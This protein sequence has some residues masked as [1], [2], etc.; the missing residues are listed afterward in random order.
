MAAH[1]WLDSLSEDWP[2]QPP[3]EPSPL[4]KDHSDLPLPENTRPSASK[5]PSPDRIPAIWGGASKMKLPGTVSPLNERTGNHANIP[6]STRHNTGSNNNTQNM[7]KTSMGTIASNANSIIHNTVHIS[8]AQGVNGYTPEWKRRLLQ[9]ELGYGEQRDLFHSA[10][11]EGLENI[12][13]PPLSPPAPS[14]PANGVTSCLDSIR[15]SIEYD[16][17]PPQDYQD[18][19]QHNTTLPSSPPVYHIRR[20]AVSKEFEDSLASDFL[21]HSPSPSPRKLPTFRTNDDSQSFSADRSLQWPLKSLHDNLNANL[22]AHTDDTRKPSNLSVMRNETFSPIIVSPTKNKDGQL[23]LEFAALG[24][25]AMDFRQRLESLRLSR[26]EFSCKTLASN[27]FESFRA[28][29]SINSPEQLLHNEALVNTQRDRTSREIS[30][31]DRFLS[32]GLG[33]ESS[34]MLP[35]ESLQA[36]TPKNFSSVRIDSRPD[37]RTAEAAHQPP[38]AQ[39]VIM[40]D[41]GEDNQAPQ[42]SPLK[43][44]GPYDTYTNQ[45][46]VR[47]ISQFE[48]EMSSSVREPSPETRDVKRKLESEDDEIDGDKSRKLHNFGHG[49]LE[50]FT[51]DESSASPARTPEHESLRHIMGLSHAT[52]EELLIPRARTRGHNRGRSIT[53]D[54]S[55]SNTNHP[56]SHPLQLTPRRDGSLEGK[57]QRT[58]PSKDPTPKRRRTLHKSDVAY[59]VDDF[60]HQVQSTHLLTQS[61]DSHDVGESYMRS[62]RD[63]NDP[64]ERQEHNWLK[65]PP[66]SRSRTPS[67]LYDYP[68]AP[69]SP[70]FSVSPSPAATP[71]RATSMQPNPL[72]DRKPSMK[73]QDF[74][75]EAGKIMAMIRNQV[76]PSSTLDPVSESVTEQ[77]E[78][79]EDEDSY[80][81]ST[82]EP[83]DR[84]PSRENAIPVSRLTM[85][86]MDPEIASKLRKYQELGDM[87]DVISY[88]VRSVSEAHVVIK[89]TQELQQ[90]LEE[91][92]RQTD[93]RKQQAAEIANGGFSGLS[94]ADLP[95]DAE[96]SD[97]PNIQITRNPDISGNAPDQNQRPDDFPSQGSRVSLSNTTSSR[98]SD[99]KK[100]IAPE[101]V[102]HLIPDLVG[103]MF[104]D[105]DK[106]AWVKRK[107]SQPKLSVHPPELPKNGAGGQRQRSG[108][109]AP[110]EVRIPSPSGLAPTTSVLNCDDSSE[111]DPFASIPDLSVDLTKELNNLKLGPGKQADEQAKRFVEVN[112]SPSKTPP[113]SKGTK[114]YVTFSPDTAIG[115]NISPRAFDEFAKLGSRSPSES[116]SP[117]KQQKRILVHG[118]GLPQTTVTQQPATKNRN[119]ILSEQPSC[120]SS[121]APALV[122]APT[123]KPTTPN[124]PLTQ[125]TKKRNAI[126][127]SSPIASVIRDVSTGSEE[128][129]WDL[130]SAPQI[131]SADPDNS[132]ANTP[133]SPT[134]SAL[135]PSLRKGIANPSLKPLSCKPLVT[136][137]AFVPRPVSRIDEREEDDGDGHSPENSV[138]GNYD[139]SRQLT[140]LENSVVEHP[141]SAEKKANTS[142]SF[143][144][145]TP[146]NR[147]IQY[148]NYGNDSATIARNVGRLSLSPLSEFTMHADESYA[149][150]VSY[151]VGDRHLQTGDGYKRVMSIT[152]RD[153]VERLTEAEPSATFWDDL[154]DL[155][156]HE[157]RL[158]SL[159]MLDE[160]CGQLV[161]LDASTNSLTHLDGVPSSLRQLKVTHNSITEMASWDHLMNLQY[162]DLSNNDL[163]SLSALRNLVHLRSVR[164]DNNQLTSLD[165]LG[166]HDGLLS[167][168]AR[169]NNIEELDFADCMF[170]RLGELDVSNN[171]IF[172][173]SNIEAL[174][175]LAVLKLRN[176]NLS[177][178]YVSSKMSSLRDLELGNNEIIS[179]DL[180]YLGSLRVLHA[181]R[182]RITELSHAYHARHLDSLSLR[183][184]HGDAPLNL[185]FLAHAY[186]V[187][188]LF[189]SG[190]SIE[191]FNP[192]VDFLNLQLLELANCGLRE[193]P[194]NL[195]QCMPNLR[196]VNVNFNALE[197]LSPLM[198][199]PRVKRLLAAGNLL[200]DATAIT[201]LLTEFPHI[202]RL[203]LRGN[204]MTL[205]FYPPVMQVLSLSRGETPDPFSLPDVDLERDRAFSTRLDRVTKMRRRLYHMVLVGCCGRLKMLDGLEFKRS[206][207]LGRD[208]L[209]EEI[210]K[211]GMVP[212]ELVKWSLEE[213]GEE[214]ENDNRR[215][216]LKIEGAARP[217][218]LTA[219]EPRKEEKKERR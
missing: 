104:L 217:P 23:E 188:K 203:D 6:E 105:R 58:S 13:K 121:T 50:G 158:S 60:P 11:A 205:G 12:F 24:P 15:P 164:V 168:R 133:G 131:L 46:L 206:E 166:H 107:E 196:T 94:F 146:T 156:L 213:Q 193:L 116:L 59:G 4:P 75:D 2:S 3:S 180:R 39:S 137:L 129:R 18:Y 209:S 97:P 178:F 177:E 89:E 200:S 198:F 182:N 134:K 138:S 120:S 167:I 157:N 190:N 45:F 112:S 26:P 153:L 48:N 207:I 16:E 219:V 71:F 62:A 99:S 115:E 72:S 125:L 10:A 148:Y 28:D 70:E 113:G 61:S 170:R 132:T 52:A 174:P 165:G 122:S 172:S 74:L 77:G 109:H 86:Q 211:E 93:E 69:D 98:A 100:T 88:S 30:I 124:P 57:R 191:I 159:H 106:K 201:R 27:V 181:D 55:N 202:S 179:L 7:R 17:P 143:V 160:F 47:R 31:G 64:P 53:T 85:H 95:H 25:P 114:G 123:P 40:E 5:S 29:T 81:S 155:D 184:Q 183:E 90:K 192:P 127:F 32:P 82:K 92:H 41:D 189:L 38:Q 83:F 9:G 151:V 152:V 117:V 80:Q 208:V 96:F 176:N 214:G 14:R 87:N 33:M 218:Q 44:F 67:P 215:K 79:V 161:K 162:L 185:S 21:V 101:S 76:R 43:L 194:R 154:E 175:V 22:A 91:R 102:S 149:L 119:K 49:D 103:N 197:D 108:T 126:S 139:E 51:F 212:G 54:R 35:E 19:E 65:S 128:S 110:L 173:V 68:D 144:L 42:R 145:T 147:G 195:G 37:I 78:E 34:E 73:T 84:P 135:K 111:G 20:P 204:P 140:I 56:L 8:D 1:A 36:S 142:L 187:R 141:L 216:I 171:K 66:R 150:E 130:P 118:K 186:E 210:V 163:K 136:R 169:G 63:Q 199:I